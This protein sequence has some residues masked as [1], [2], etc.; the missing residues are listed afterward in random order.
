MKV[1]IWN[2]LL[3]FWLPTWT[4]YTNLANFLK[5]WLNFG[6]WN[7]LSYLIL[8]FLVFNK[9]FWLYVASKRKAKVPL[10]KILKFFLMDETKEV[11]NWLE[12]KGVWQ[13]MNT[14]KLKKWMNLEIKLDN[15]WIKTSWKKWMNLG[16]GII[17]GKN[18][19]ENCEK[20]GS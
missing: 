4:V 19:I 7:F 15:W 14:R 6:Y 20:S 12:L 5:L 17:I 11:L 9:A 18:K 13:R 8:S 1:E 10:C 2:I 3:Y 16:L